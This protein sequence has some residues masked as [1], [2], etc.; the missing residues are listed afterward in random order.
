MTSNWMLCCLV[1]RLLLHS[2]PC[3]RLHIAFRRLHAISCCRLSSCWNRCALVVSGD[4]T[5]FL[6]A[7]TTPQRTCSQAAQCRFSMRIMSELN[8]ANGLMRS[9]APPALLNSYWS[10]ACLRMARCL[11]HLS[12]KETLITGLWR[13][14]AQ[15]CVIIIQCR[16]FLLKVMKSNL[17]KPNV[18]FL[19]R[20]LC[21]M[22]VQVY[23]QFWHRWFPVLAVLQHNSPS[24]IQP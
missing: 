22:V 2:A 24:S 4:T 9:A 1:K 15:F 7:S 12:Y 16:S 18:M 3:C 23:L 19:I 13:S 8:T 21:N 10:T 17:T 5:R 14:T 6:I 11:L 20:F